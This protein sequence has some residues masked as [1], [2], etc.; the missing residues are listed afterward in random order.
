MRGPLGLCLPLPCGKAEDIWS[1][2]AVER[3]PIESRT[4][5]VRLSL[6]RS[7]RFEIEGWRFGYL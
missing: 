7:T 6:V 1:S 5:R 3:A 2:S 4:N